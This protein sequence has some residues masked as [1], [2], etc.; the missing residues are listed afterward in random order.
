MLAFVFPGQGAQRVGMG[1]TLV[2]RFPCAEETFQQADEA[3]GFS[4]SNLC[5]EG[6]EDRLKL[7]AYSQPA[8][9]TT[10]VAVLR[11]V[12]EQTDLKPAVLAGHSLGEFVALVA[13]GALDLADAVRLVHKRGQFMQEAVPEGQGAMAAV[14][15]LADDVVRQLCFEAAGDQ[16][17]APAN[18]NGGKQVVIAGHAEAVQRAMAAAKRSGGRSIP[19]KVSAPFHCPLMA[20]AA[21]KLAA[22]L[23]QVSFRTPQVQVIRNVD[24]KPYAAAE[25]IPRMLLQQVTSPVLWEA[26]VRSVVEMGVRQVIELGPGK[27]LSGLVKRIAGKGV[28]ASSVEG[29]DQIDLLRQQH[30]A[31]A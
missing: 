21:E 2:D 1:K 17:V 5:F 30:F 8:I 25:E 18:Y 28:P 31:A 12:S 6:P 22:E 29:A 16:V 19:L 14:I 20:P 9:L 27:V 11:V 3:L 4:V 26:T 13:A 15:G 7:T 23:A 10:S 24:A